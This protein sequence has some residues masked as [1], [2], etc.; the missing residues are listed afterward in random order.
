VEFNFQN[1]DSILACPKCK[2]DVYL[3]DASLWCETCKVSYPILNNI[4]NFLHSPTTDAEAKELKWVEGKTVFSQRRTAWNNNQQEEPRANQIR[5]FADETARKALAQ[6]IERITKTLRSKIILDIGNGGKLVSTD[7]DTMVAIDISQTVMNRLSQQAG[8]NVQLD[9]PSV[10]A[11]TGKAQELPFKNDSFDLTF[12]SG[13]LHH[14]GGQQK[15]E[16]TAVTEM[17]R[18]TRQG[19]YILA[20]EPNLLY[21]A[22]ILMNLIGT[23]SESVFVNR[24]GFVPH[25]RSLS[26]MKL[27]SFFEKAGCSKIGISGSTF[28]FNLLPLSIQRG[29]TNS[30]DRLVETP[31]FSFLSCWTIVYAKK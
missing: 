27:V 3:N 24:F 22:G 8:Q 19:G 7:I 31:P 20:L 17:R 28:T 4:P 6:Q 18:V 26:P 13:L 10:I 11:I 9:K 12:C 16:V 1:I 23:L 21:P 15:S 5:R 14:L 29:I 30:L 2:G 25:E